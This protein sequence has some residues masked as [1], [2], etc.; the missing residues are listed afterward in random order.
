M[1]IE[2]VFKNKHCEWIDVES[3]TQEDLEFLHQKFNIDYLLL[4]DT[5]DANHL[6]KYEE[7]SHLK[8]FLMRES[9]EENRRN[10]N[11][12]SDVSTKLGLYL[13]DHYIITIHRMQKRSIYETKK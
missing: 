13:V 3:A 2:Q 5:I 7:D 4:E 6:P 9:T 10:L 8:F 11:S 12:I 1:A